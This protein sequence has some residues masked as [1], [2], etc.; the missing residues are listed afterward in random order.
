MRPELLFR[1]PQRTLSLRGAQRRSNPLPDEPRYARQARDCFVAARLAMTGL[2]GFSTHGENAPNPASRNDG[3]VSQS[4]AVNANIAGLSSYLE[5]RE[6]RRTVPLAKAH[7]SHGGRTEDTVHTESEMPRAHGAPPAP[8]SPWSSAL[9]PC[10]NAVNHAAPAMG[11]HARSLGCAGLAWI[12]ISQVMTRFMKCST[13]EVVS[14]SFIQGVEERDPGATIPFTVETLD[15]HQ[16]TIGSPAASPSSCRLQSGHPRYLADANSESRGLC[17]F[18]HHDTAR[19]RVGQHLPHLVR[20][21][22]P[23]G[24]ENPPARSYQ[25][26]TSF[27]PRSASRR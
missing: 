26:E 11:F 5:T 4:G 3:N 24:G 23:P 12:R 17:A 27:T 1:F 9:P 15:W 25:H 16:T 6:H 19:P 14:W 13:K 21:Y 22:E 10:E 2:A 18:T 20:L 8:C 7:F